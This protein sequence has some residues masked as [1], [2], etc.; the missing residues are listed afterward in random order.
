MRSLIVALALCATALSARAGEKEEQEAKDREFERAAAADAAEGAKSGLGLPSGTKTELAAIERRRNDRPAR[1]GLLLEGGFPEGA[2]ASVVFRP[3][4]EVRL[5]AGPA[6]NYVAFGMQAGVTL[7]PWQ[8]GFSPILS[9]EAGRYFNADATFLANKAS[10]V[11]PEVKPLLTN[12]SYD[13]AAAHVGFEIGTRDAFA[14][15]LRAG[16]SY[17]SLTANGTTT[18]TGSSGGSTATVTF[19]DPNLRGTI[20]SVKVGVQ[21]WF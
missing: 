6:W 18:T 12:V 4:S 8:A 17:V 19:T 20:P 5:W 16:L 9:L 14:I 2:A 10:G 3:V 7:I 13:Y 21:L 15:S 1:W 11:P